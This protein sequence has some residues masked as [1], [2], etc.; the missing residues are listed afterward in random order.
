MNFSELIN[1]LNISGRKIKVNIINP[2][3]NAECYKT[4]ELVGYKSGIWGGGHKFKKGEM[5]S[6]NGLN[7][8]WVKKPK[9]QVAYNTFT[10]GKSQHSDWI[11]VDNCDFEIGFETK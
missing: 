10:F 6:F 2:V 5:T 3:R 11:D 1:E 7:R 9:V 4:G 8:G